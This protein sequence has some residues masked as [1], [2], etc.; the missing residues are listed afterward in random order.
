MISGN[1]FT[2]LYSSWRRKQLPKINCR[3]GCTPPQSGNYSGGG[4]QPM[5]PNGT[6]SGDGVFLKGLVAILC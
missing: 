2:T 3:K 1:L 4:S 5:L 6:T